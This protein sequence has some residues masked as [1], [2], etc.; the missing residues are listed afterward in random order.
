MLK[1]RILRQD[2][3]DRNRKVFRGDMIRCLFQD[4]NLRNNT[5]VDAVIHHLLQ[6]NGGVT[7]L[8]EPCCAVDNAVKQ[9]VQHLAAV[10][11]D[12]AKTDQ[13]S[14]VILEQDTKKYK[15][16]LMAGPQGILLEPR[17]ATLV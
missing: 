9:R 12:H 17:E 8:F 11:Q 1:T 3:T 16:K 7:K 14:N 4:I 6:A 5:T 13:A 15:S 2:R 10:L